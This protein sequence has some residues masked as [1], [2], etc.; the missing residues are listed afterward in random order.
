M[1]VL[2][3]YTEL[4]IGSMF[5]MIMNGLDNHTDEKNSTCLFKMLTQHILQVNN[6]AQF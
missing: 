2:I 6:N 4:L 5:G 1:H 3:L